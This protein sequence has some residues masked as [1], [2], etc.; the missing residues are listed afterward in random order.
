MS[1]II[2]RQVASASIIEGTPASVIKVEDTVMFYEATS[3]MPRTGF[4]VC[5]T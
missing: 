1:Y 2:E 4:Q 5:S 3:C